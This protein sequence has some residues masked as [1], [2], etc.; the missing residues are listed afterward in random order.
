[1]PASPGI[2]IIPAYAGSTYVNSTYPALAA[3]SSPHTRGARRLDPEHHHRIRIIPAYAGST[4]ARLMSMVRSMDHP[5][6]RGEHLA[7]SSLHILMHGSSPHTR[8]APVGKVVHSVLSRIIPAYAGSTR[9]RGMGHVCTR[10]HPRIRGEHS[11]IFAFR[12]ARVGSSPHTRGALR[13]E[14]RAVQERGII[15]AY[16]GSTSP[17]SR[18]FGSPQDHPRIR[19]EHLSH[20]SSLSS[21]E[22]SSPHTRGARI[23]QHGQRPRQGII[24]A[25]AG[26]T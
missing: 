12:P 10:D 16:A 20:C 17:A 23:P 3:G 9:C 4:L 15:P 21:L 25:Y 22:G 24:P 2:R 5:R 11:C 1:M 7:S 18:P 8:G 26:S 6:I 19:G 14:Q 13:E